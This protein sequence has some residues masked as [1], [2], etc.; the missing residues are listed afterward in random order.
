MRLLAD[1]PAPGDNNVRA[2]PHGRAIIPPRDGRVQRRLC[3]F[4]RA[5]VTF[6][7]DPWRAM[8]AL[9]SRCRVPMTTPARPS[10]AGASGWSPS[11]ACRDPCGQLHRAGPTMSVH[12][13]LCLAAAAIFTVFVILARFVAGP[14]AAAV[15]GVAV[16]DRCLGAR[17]DLVA[18]TSLTPGRSRAGLSPTVLRAPASAHPRLLARFDPSAVACGK[19]VGT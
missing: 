14:R 2:L 7:S 10:I 18:M 16:S 15:T 3:S 5:C 19:W 11:L 8:I 12:R 13:S 4:L 17:S 9:E 6:D 1:G